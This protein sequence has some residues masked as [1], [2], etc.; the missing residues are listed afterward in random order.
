MLKGWVL[1]YCDRYCEY[2]KVFPSIVVRFIVPQEFM[3]IQILLLTLQE[4]AND[5]YIC[6][7]ATTQKQRRYAQVIKRLAN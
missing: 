7:V 4:P 2:S 1:K 5:A 6:T 3:K